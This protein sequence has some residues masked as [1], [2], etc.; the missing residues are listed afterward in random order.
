MNL[1]ELFNQSYFVPS[2]ECWNWC[3]QQYFNHQSNLTIEA[4]IIPAIAV[5]CLF[6]FK[7]ILTFDTYILENTDIDIDNLQKIS[8]LLI[9]F[10]ILLM[11]GFF[12]WF[13]FFS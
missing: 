1:S 13:K 11:I 12:I 10:A 5:L 8:L 4:M 3:S 7:I 9:D 2:D 6:A